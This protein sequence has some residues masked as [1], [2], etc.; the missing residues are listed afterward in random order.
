MFKAKYVLQGHS[1]A[2]IAS[3]HLC[4]KDTVARVL[5]GN[6]GTLRE[7]HRHHGRPSQPAYGWNLKDGELQQDLPEQRVIKAVLDLRQAGMSLRQIARYLDD[8]GIPTK[9]YGITWHPEMVS[10]ILKTSAQSVDK[11]K[12]GQAIA[13]MLEQRWDL[14][15]T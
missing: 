3:Q 4:S 2:Q 9:L 15:G 10:R 1:L 5:R 6:G 13:D 11:K 14:S 8:V 12:K 7:P